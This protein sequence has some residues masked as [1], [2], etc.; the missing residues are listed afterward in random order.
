M[1]PSNARDSSSEHFDS[2]QDFLNDNCDISDEVV[3]I[4]SGDCDNEGDSDSMPLDSQV[5]ES[6]L[7]GTCEGSHGVRGSSKLVSR[8]HSFCDKFFDVATGHLN[9]FQDSDAQ[10]KQERVEIIASLASLE[11]H[12]SLYLDHAI[13]EHVLGRV[14]CCVRA[15]VVPLIS[16]KLKSLKVARKCIPLGQNSSCS[17]LQIDLHEVHETEILDV[18]CVRLTH[19]QVCDIL[20]TVIEEPILNELS[21]RQEFNCDSLVRDTCVIKGDEEENGWTKVG[22]SG[23]RVKGGKKENFPFADEASVCTEHSFSNHCMNRKDLSQDQKG[24]DT[25]KTLRRMSLSG[26]GPLKQVALKDAVEKET[27]AENRNERAAQ[28][29]LQHRFTVVPVDEDGSCMYHAFLEACRLSHVEVSDTNV[30]VVRE[31]VREYLEDQIK[32]RNPFFTE[33]SLDGAHGCIRQVFIDSLEKDTNRM[34]PGESP[35]YFRARMNMAAANEKEFQAFIDETFLPGVFSAHF[36]HS[37]HAFGDLAEQKAL[38]TLYNVKIKTFTAFL[39]NRLLYTSLV[40]PGSGDENSVIDLPEVCLLLIKEHY[41]AVRLN[42]DS[43]LRLPGLEQNANAQA[44]V[45]LNVVQEAFEGDLQDSEVSN[46][47]ELPPKVIESHSVEIEVSCGAAD[48]FLVVE[49]EVEESVAE[50]E[51]D[52]EFSETENSFVDIDS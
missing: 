31:K 43:I 16:Q 6:V 11:E 7:D 20:E 23:K 30:F 34:R 45:G 51:D 41:W 9:L 24:V 29:E 46:E 33:W 42:D 39:T 22:R 37:K 40:V 28:I 2:K 36:Q 48:S 13:S 52:V 21:N 38:A 44:E 3:A 14:F 8:I 15:F 1:E 17:R 49:S 50:T 5:H 27:V 47:Q 32:A 10:S 12:V 25:G 26:G 19:Q 4:E 35:A 18:S